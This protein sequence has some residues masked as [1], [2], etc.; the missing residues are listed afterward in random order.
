[1]Q[2]NFAGNMNNMHIAV[3]A[4]DRQK[5][6]LLE[7][8]MRANVSVTWLNHPAENDTD[9]D[10]LFDL[11]SGENIRRH[12]LAPRSTPVFVNA[13]I[14][15]TGE[16]PPHCIRINAW[17]GFLK[18]GLTEVA[19]SSNEMKEKASAILE[20]IGWS[21]AWAP[22]EPGMISARII[23]MI[24]NEAYF[25][26]GEKISTR[27]QIDTAMKLGTNYPYGPFEWGERIGL[28]NICALLE[29]LRQK[30]SRYQ[31]APLLLKEAGTNF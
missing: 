3:F 18:N 23:A 28:Q 6:E 20:A 17:N 22:D 19:A 27:D 9:F 2:P 4:D 21:F 29:K 8:G 1:M 25:A 31:I 15:T 30:E 16:L 5:K 14:T 12:A 13:V 10:A 7:K 11:A 26:L 24:V